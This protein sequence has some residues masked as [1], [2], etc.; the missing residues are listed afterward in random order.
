MIALK[1]NDVKKIGKL[2]LK[3]KI[4]LKERLEG[5]LLEDLAPAVK[6]LLLRYSS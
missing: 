3:R 5:V 4:E 2:D 1:E 6:L